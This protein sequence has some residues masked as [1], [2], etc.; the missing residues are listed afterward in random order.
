MTGIRELIEKFGERFARFSFNQKVLLGAL[1]AAAVISLVIFSVWLQ[2]EE[3]AVLFSGLS[4]Q[5]ASLAL[6]ELEKL[7]IKTDLA[8]GGSTILVPADQMHR[9][10]I[11]LMGKG[12]P[13]SGVVGFE[14]FDGKQYGLTEFL[15][16]VNFKRALEGELTKTIES[17]SGI[18]SARVHLAIPKP[19]IFK[20]TRSQTT[21]SVVVELARG[22]RLE[23]GQ[24]H[25]IQSLVAGSV[26]GLENAEV[27]IHD[28][29][30]KVLS[31]AV[32][33]DDAGRSESQLA[34][35][36]EVEFHLAEKA[37]GLLDTAL[38]AGRSTVSSGSRES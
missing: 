15:Q 6:S 38:G 31:S 23:E 9:L 22:I 33:D 11:D 16:N 14:I 24:I 36:K 12:I 7:G 30:G 3:Q 26:E 20:K 27:R 2:S 25:G 13:S 34:L 5:D 17:L 35:R 8:S 19:S 32:K 29:N 4:P 10:R 37:R 21:A 28:Q 1:S 18:Q